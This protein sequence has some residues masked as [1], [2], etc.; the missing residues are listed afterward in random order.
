ML[1]GSDASDAEAEA[2]QAA[3]GPPNELAVLAAAL[4][5]PSAP[6]ARPEARPG[7][8]RSLEPSTNH[9]ILDDLPG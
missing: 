2:R 8:E 4:L 3:L 7:L 6:P 1:R 9:S 5:R